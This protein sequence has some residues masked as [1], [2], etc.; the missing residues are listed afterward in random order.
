MNC[1]NGGP[2]SNNKKKGFVLTVKVESGI[3]RSHIGDKFIIMPKELIVNVKSI[4]REED[5][6]DYAKAGDTVD[7]VVQIAKEEDFE[8]IGR[9]NIITTTVYPIPLVLKLAD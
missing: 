7:L 4:F 9:G 5:K 3:I 2:S 6:I 1:S 8:S